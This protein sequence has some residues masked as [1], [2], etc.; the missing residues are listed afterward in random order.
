LN[1]M[2]LK[3]I[4]HH[5]WINLVSF[6][7]S[8]AAEFANCKFQAAKSRELNHSFTDEEMWLAKSSRLSCNLN[9]AACKLKLGEYL[10]ASIS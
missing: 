2:K 7:S 3:K 4:N 1:A 8:W 9:D 5:S 6:F 10:E